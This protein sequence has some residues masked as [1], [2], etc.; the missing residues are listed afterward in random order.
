MFIEGI[1]ILFFCQN[2]YVNLVAR[3]NW[4]RQVAIKFVLSC[5]PDKDHY[6]YS[7]KYT[8]QKKDYSFTLLAKLTLPGKHWDS[9][10]SKDVLVLTTPFSFW[11]QVQPVLIQWSQSPE[12]RNIFGRSSLLIPLKDQSQRITEKKVIRISLEQLQKIG[13]TSK[14]NF[15][16]QKLP[17]SIT[18]NFIIYA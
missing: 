18:T 16:I 14:S 15:H 8:N 11:F 12:F 13:S 4:L 9:S 2:R 17:L 7:V 5:C 10:V 6:K 3:L 1:P